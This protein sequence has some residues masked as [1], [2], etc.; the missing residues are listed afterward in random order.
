MV[1]CAAT[2]V[3]TPAA[4]RIA[5]RWGVLD[6]PLGP[7]KRHVKPTPYLGGIAV[8]L[9]ALG[10]M[11]CFGSLGPLANWAY[12][13]LLLLLGT[14]DDLRPL[15]P[16][17]KLLGQCLAAALFIWLS[18]LGRDE[19]AYATLL[20]LSLVVYANAVNLLDILDGLATGGTAIILGCLSVVFLLSDFIPEGVFL[21]S[22]AGATLGFLPWN[23]PRAKIFLGDGGSL[24]LGGALGVGVSRGLAVSLESPQIEFLFALAMC[25][26][27]PVFDLSFVILRRVTQGLNPLKGSPDHFAIKMVLRRGRP[28]QAV[29]LVWVLCAISG[30]AAIHTV[31]STIAIHAVFA[32]V[33]LMLVYIV[34][35][36][37]AWRHG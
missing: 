37:M 20:G 25:G 9:G 30:F 31:I 17:A 32:L 33:P 36:A 7:L 3:L 14:L 18:G 1:A 27:L 11:L 28:I 16:S 34:L 6:Y 4:M 26:S 24:V 2:C 10:G 21:A 5:C 19:L 13:T 15:S 12:L 23:F 22:C 29:V 8:L 35:G